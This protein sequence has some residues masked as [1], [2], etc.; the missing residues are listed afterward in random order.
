MRKLLG[1]SSNAFDEIANLVGGL[2]PSA[3]RHRPWWANDARHV[4]AAAW[5]AAGWRTEAV[6]LDRRQVTFHSDG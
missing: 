5:M 4:Q 6:D 2:P 1:A 3:F